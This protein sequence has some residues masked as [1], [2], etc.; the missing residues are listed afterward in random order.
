MTHRRSCNLK[1]RA[2]L[3]RAMLF[4]AELGVFVQEKSYK[5]TQRSLLDCMMSGRSALDMNHGMISGPP[6]LN[7]TRRAYCEYES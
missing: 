1:F 3:L 6:A 5:S 2:K 4:L 7:M